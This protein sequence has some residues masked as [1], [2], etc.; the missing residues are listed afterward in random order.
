MLRRGPLGWVPVGVYRLGLSECPVEKEFKWNDKFEIVQGEEFFTPERFLVFPGGAPRRVEGGYRTVFGPVFYHPS[1]VY[2]KSDSNMAKALTRQTGRR[3]ND[4]L[5]PDEWYRDNQRKAIKSSP[6]LAEIVSTVRSRIEMEFTGV[7]PHSMVEEYAVAPNKKR[8]ER[9]EEMGKLK[10]NGKW[11]A[12]WDYLW[13]RDVTGEVKPGEWAKWGKY[14]RL[15]VSLG[16]SSIFAAGFLID[17]IKKCFGSVVLDEQYEAQFVKSPQKEVLQDV[18]TKLIF[19]CKTLYMAYFS[20]DSCVAIRT[21]DGKL[22]SCNMDISSCDC[23]HTGKL[24]Y[25][26]KY[27]CSAID[28]VG[29]AIGLAIKQCSA[30]ITITSVCRTRGGKVVLQPVEPVLYSGST[31]TTILNNVSQLLMFAVMVD[32]IRRDGPPK[33]SECRTFIQ[34][35]AEICGYIVTIEGDE[36]PQQLQFLKHSPAIDHDGVKP[37]LN[38]GVVLRM[39]GS[40]FG[41]LPGRGPIPHRAYMW[42][43]S[44]VMGLVHSGLDEYLSEVRQYYRVDENIAE[45]RELRKRAE[46]FRATHVYGGMV[47]S[48]EQIAARYDLQVFEVEELFDMMMTPGHIVCE[49]LASR[50]IYKLDYGYNL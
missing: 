14:P 17:G 38:L 6:A 33:F 24:F 43:R 47:A 41:D 46:E 20:D 8:V 30:R 34:G 4:P 35:C 5:K 32:R 15:F 12:C 21:S 16:V 10:N 9:I 1:V 26:L 13:H 44:L 2:S 42:N 27:I 45:C 37:Y 40:C 11:N 31:L 39:F 23:S 19:G 48:K 25:L 18:F 7:D 36:K 3:S 49:T 22:Y 50:A 28:W 29:Y